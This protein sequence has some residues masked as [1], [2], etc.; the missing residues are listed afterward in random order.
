MF[1]IY[2]FLTHAKQQ[3]GRIKVAGDSKLR[4]KSPGGRFSKAL[5][6]FQAHKAI[7]RSSV[8]KNREVYTPETSC[9]KGTSLHL[10]DM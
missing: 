9:M 4:N 1:L 10:Q 5:E 2:I 7:F 8:S 6:T 3:V